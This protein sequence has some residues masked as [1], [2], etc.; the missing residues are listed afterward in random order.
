MD[1]RTTSIVAGIIF[2]TVKSPLDHITF[3]RCRR[4]ADHICRRAYGCGASA[5]IRPHCQRPG[6]HGQIDAVCSGQTLND[7]YH[8]GGK[9][10]IIHKGA[11]N[12]GQPYDDRDHDHDVSAADPADKSRHDLQD[13]R[14][15]Q[16]AD[17]DKQADEEQQRFIVHFF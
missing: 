17:H 12:R 1:S 3:P 10:D 9:R 2:F 14:L 11:D 6:E 13:S 5:D 15:F 7:R 4:D 8:R 16:S